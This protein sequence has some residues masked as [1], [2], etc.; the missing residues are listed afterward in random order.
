MN[1]AHLFAGAGGGLLADLILGH[2]PILAVEWNEACCISLRERS[3]EGWFP[4]LYVHHGDIQKFD[5]KPWA[6]R[7][8]CLSAGF[9]CQDISAAGPGEGIKGKR[10]GLVSEVFRAIDV[11]RPGIVW[12]ENSPRI[13]TKGRHVVIKELVERGYSWRDGKLA[14]SDVGAPHER[15]RWWC[16]AANADGMRKL[17]Q[18]R[19]FYKQ[20]GWDSDEFEEITDIDGQHGDMGR[21]HA[22]Q[23]S[24]L[25]TSGIS[26]CKKNT[27]NFVQSGP[28]K[29]RGTDS[30][31]KR[32]GQ[33]SDSI[34]VSANFLF[35][36]LQSAIQCGGLSE[37]DA[38][39]IKAAA[40]YTGAYY[41]S[42]P[43]IGICGM[44]DGMAT[45]MDGNTKTERIKASGNGQVPVAAAAAWLKLLAQV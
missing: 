6:G 30:D 27:P 41:W 12:L 35:D 44:V 45:P 8:D 34:E 26:T 37:A 29:L 23:V 36:R 16:L 43:D 21:L 20:W 40:G 17:E 19:S 25:N 3:A 22:S 18:E 39:T 10:S 14:A 4:E 11:I 32:Q 1:V 13:R 15:Y 7:V 33:T 5:F 42:P 2:D 9:P 28:Q 38:E 24:Q 31:K